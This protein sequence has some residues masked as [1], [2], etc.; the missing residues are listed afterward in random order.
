MIFKKLIEGEILEFNILALKKR[1]K[2][3]FY[4]LLVKRINHL[5]YKKFQ[6]LILKPKLRN[7][8]KKIEIF[9]FKKNFEIPKLQD[10]DLIKKKENLKKNNFVFF[11]NLLE[12]ND[13]KI[14]KDKFENEKNL[15]DVYTNNKNFSYKNKPDSAR[16]GYIPTENIFDNECILEAANNKKLITLL[17]NYFNCKYSLDWAWAWWSFKSEEI[18]HGPQNFHRD[19]ESLNFIKVFIYLTDVIDEKDGCHEFVLASSH[20]NEFYK[21]ER[22]K[23]KDIENKFH[24]K[25]KKIFGSAGTTFIVDSFGIHRGVKP[26]SKDRLVISLLYS[27]FPSNRS[28]K[29]PPIY[30]SNLR[31]KDLYL[32]NK[33]LNRLFVNFDK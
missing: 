25:V 30:F 7:I 23:K 16:M 22:F 6:R 12:M 18:D 3:S 32:K 1:D 13:I 19:Y 15:L 17:D 21:R 4:Y 10:S 11:D 9:F 26:V 31:N 2:I 33:Y 24:C 28:P 14:I 8:L 27:V 20:K 29:I 5:I